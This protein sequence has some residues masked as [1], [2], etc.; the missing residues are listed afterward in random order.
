[1]K[2]CKVCK[3]PILPVKRATILDTCMSCGSYAAS[4]VRHTVVPMHKS[5]YTVVTSR[6]S[7][8]Q[9]NPKKGV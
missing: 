4:K 2:L 8:S 7:L 3:L 1:M 9:L 6:T 5:N